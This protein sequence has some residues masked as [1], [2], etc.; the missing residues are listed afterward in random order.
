MKTDLR[1]IDQLRTQRASGYYNR[2]LQLKDT[3]YLASEEEK[4]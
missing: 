3:G 4:P 2:V 1:H